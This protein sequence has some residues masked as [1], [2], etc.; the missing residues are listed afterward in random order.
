MSTGRTLPTGVGAPVLLEGL[1]MIGRVRPLLALHRHP[2]FL[3]SSGGR[4]GRRFCGAREGFGRVEQLAGLQAVV[5]AAEVRLNR[6]RI[7]AACLSPG[8]AATVV[9]RWAPGEGS[10]PKTHT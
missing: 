3:P 2:I 10:A 6:L 4:C 9:V 8:R 5:E 7:A 1:K